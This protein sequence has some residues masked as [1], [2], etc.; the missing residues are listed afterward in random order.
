MSTTPRGA[1]HRDN[2]DATTTSSVSEGMVRRILDNSV[3]DQIAH[4][5]QIREMLER[6]TGGKVECNGVKTV[7]QEKLF[8]LTTNSLT[9]ENE[10]RAGVKQQL[11]YPF[12][13]V[14]SPTLGMR[15]D[16]NYLE[17]FERGFP[18]LVITRR[19]IYAPP[20]GSMPKTI[21]R[22]VFIGLLFFGSINALWW[23]FNLE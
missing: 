3:D 9:Y 6:V 21:A 7:G 17:G 4:E 20:K 22:T 8:I 18:T 12:N 16:P 13:I 2:D 15:D 14:H 5:K 11:L 10:L 23:L 19:G 1:R